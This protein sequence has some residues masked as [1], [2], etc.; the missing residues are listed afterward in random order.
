MASSCN[1]SVKVSMLN[2]SLF[3]AD[4]SRDEEIARKLFGGLNLD[5]IGPP[6]DGKIIIL[7][8]DDSRHDSKMECTVMVTSSSPTHGAA[9]RRRGK[10]L[11][12]PIS[13]RKRL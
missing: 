4:T 13:S 11:S 7:N 12:S 9:K 6:G 3:I 5:I 8:D 10:T 1:A 2:P